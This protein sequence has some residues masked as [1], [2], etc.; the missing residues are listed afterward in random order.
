MIKE[1]KAKVKRL[2][3]SE[4]SD[5]VIRKI[6]EYTLLDVDRL[7]NIGRLSQ[8]LNQQK[9]VGDFVECGV[10][11]GGSAALLSTYLREE[12]HLWLYDSFEGMPETSELDG[13]EAKKWVRTC[14]GSIAVV[15]EA[16]NLVSTRP[17]KYTIKKGWF[18]DTFSEEIPDRVALLHCDADWYESVLLVLRV[19]YPRIPEGGCIILDDFGHWEGCREAFYDFCR[20]YH[21]KPLL[22]RI[23]AAQAF[24]IK[25][26]SNN[27]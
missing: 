12:R 6:R 3:T 18:Q 8:Y 14:L 23:G 16:M 19:F 27:R 22:E 1:V 25:G 20:E 10:F 7:R 5:K 2:I 24:W 13:E 15:Q 26:K 17:E 11:N 21:E 4:P 9:I